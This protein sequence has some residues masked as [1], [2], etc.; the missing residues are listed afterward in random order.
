MSEF[1]IIPTKT[2]SKLLSHKKLWNFFIQLYQVIRRMVKC[3]VI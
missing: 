1:L 2:H 3:V